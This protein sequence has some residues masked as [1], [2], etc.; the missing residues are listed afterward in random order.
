M[1]IFGLLMAFSINLGV[2]IS[3]GKDIQWA[4]RVPIAFMQVFPPIPART[5]KKMQ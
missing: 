4:W 3:L 1:N 2:T 5:V